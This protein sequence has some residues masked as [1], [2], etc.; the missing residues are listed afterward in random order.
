MKLAGNPPG[1]EHAGRMMGREAMESP[2][3]VG[4]PVFATTHWS[5]VLAAAHQETPEAAAALERLGRTY[6]YPLYA[7]IRRRGHGPAD[8]PDL[9]QEFFTR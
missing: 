6:W 4:Q 1:A 3:E 5:V 9:T 2:G 8:P 7:Y